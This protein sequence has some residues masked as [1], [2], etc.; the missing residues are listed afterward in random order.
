M[1]SYPLIERWDEV[2]ELGPADR[3]RHGELPNGMKYYV[4]RTFKPKDRAALALAVD[5]GSIAEE[6][7]ERGVAH[8]VEHLAFRATESNDNFAIVRFLESIGAEFGACQNAYTSMDETVYELLV[9]I[10]KPE[11]M[12]Q[13]LKVMSEFAT[14]VRI[15]DADVNDERGAVM[16]EMR[17]G[18]DARGRAA[19]AYWKLLMDGSL[20]AERLPIGLEKVIREGK[21]E[22]FRRFY[23]KWYRPE[24]MAVIVAG[25]FDDLDAVVSQITAVFERCEAAVD[26]PPPGVAA[27]VHRPL[28]APHTSPRLTCMVDKEYTKTTVTLTFKYEANKVSTPGGFFRKTVEDAFKLVLDNRLYKIMR[29]ADPPFFSAACSME[30]ATR[31]TS[32]FSVQIVCEEGKA[33]RGLEA[34]LRELA[35]A[36]LHGFSQQELRI[37][38]AKQLAEAEQLFVERDQTYCT[39]LRD[40]L[41][42]HFLRGELVVGAEEEARLSKACIDM[43]KTADL[44]E[45]ADKLRIDH[46]CVIRVMEG[47]ATTAESDIAAAVAKIQR[48]DDLGEIT[49]NPI[50]KVP[51]SL[52]EKGKLLT[53]GQI[54]EE[55]TFPNLDFDVV[56]LENGMR[57]AMKTTNFLDDQ[58]V[59]RCFAQGGLSEVPRAEYLDALYANTIASELGM[60]G[61]KP[62]VLHDIM[63]GKRCDMSA[64]TA[65]Y[66]RRVDGDTSPV[67]IETSLQLLHILFTSDVSG[68]LVPEELEAVLRMQEQAI[69]NRRRDPVTLYNET[70][71]HL[72][73]SRSYQTRP[74]QVRDVRRMKPAEACRHFNANYSDPSEFTVVLV[75]AFDKEKVRPMI[76]KYLGSIPPAKIPRRRITEVKPAPF[77]FPRG[78]INKDLRV[79]MVEPMAMASIT[80]PVTIANPDY[81]KRLKKVPAVTLEG[82]IALTREKLMC[83]FASSIIERRLIALLRFKFG[84]IYTCSASTSFA[85]QDPQA[86]GATYR[87]DIMINFSCDPEAGHRLAALATEDVKAMQRD[88]PTL[89]EVATAVEVEQR[90]LE[91][92]VQENAYWREYFEALHNSR[93]VPLMAGDLDKLYAVT[94][95]VRSGVMR[96]LT[97]EMVRDHLQKCLKVGNRVVVVLRPQRPLWQRLLL[98]S[99]TTTEG[100]VVLTCLGGAA[101]AAMMYAKHARTRS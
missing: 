15:S 17:M 65:T 93:L 71:R 3:H 88:G 34:G 33:M 58:V 14:K 47:R 30:E 56:D 82:S 40:E 57:V 70:I 80:F 76:L 48:E 24:R 91:V 42:G 101:L 18:R 99:P 73:Y 51:E 35:R 13:A 31:T 1:T 19:E 60:Y 62:E 50:F 72:V 11:L 67:D 86:R 39:S 81:D 25:D 64:K 96:G 79:P 45:F 27:T 43:M 32:V 36:R 78:I 84:E 83:V 87:G 55:R 49:E 66:S 54:V 75:G 2:L 38:A 20:Y 59:L 85:Y 53:T 94:E 6:E 61:V 5:V 44:H 69:R 23:K 46:S 77:K 37:A 7:D 89:E 92:R 63:A 52:I 22:V 74:L 9:P 8:L 16:E 10:D 12:T 95:E 21:P 97:P 26:Q 41:V 68:M 98:P 29:R 28:I 4:Q 100:L 90:A